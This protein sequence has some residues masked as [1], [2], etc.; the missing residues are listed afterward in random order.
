MIFKIKNKNKIFN[1]S[2]DELFCLKYIEKFY[3]I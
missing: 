2:V 3:K 1:S